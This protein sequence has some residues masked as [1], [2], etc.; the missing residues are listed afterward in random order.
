M[1]KKS[2][3]GCGMNNPEH[4]YESLKKLFFGLKVL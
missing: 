1:G 2:G 3:S 4:I